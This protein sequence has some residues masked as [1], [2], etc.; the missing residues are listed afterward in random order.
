MKLT[1]IATTTSTSTKDSRSTHSSTREHSQGSG[2]LLGDGAA[3]RTAGVSRERATQGHDGL[4]SGAIVGGHVSELGLGFGLGLE[5]QHRRWSLRVCSTLA[6]PR[7]YGDLAPSAASSADQSYV[8]RL[9]SI[10]LAELGADLSRVTSID[11]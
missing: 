8:K 10:S 3:L 1:T 5:P 9:L 7:A 11:R 4:R 6:T 2:C